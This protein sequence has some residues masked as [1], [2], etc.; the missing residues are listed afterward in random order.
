[1]LLERSEKSESHTERARALSHIGHLYIR[2]L[3]DQE[4]GVYALAQALAQD[5][6]SDAYATDLERAAGSDMKVW[7]EALHLLSEV[8][9]HPRMPVEPK[10]CLFLRLGAWYSEKVAR[11][12][13]GIPCYQAVLAMDPA[14]DAALAGVGAIYRRAQQWAEFGQVLLRRAVV[15]SQPVEHVFIDICLVPQPAAIHQVMAERAAD[16]F[17]L[18]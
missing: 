11:P 17:R 18:R 4:Q 7:G 5:V 1:M 6:M 2:E 16:G 15:A 8:T 13:L 9:T 10:I 3:D 14:N 12:D